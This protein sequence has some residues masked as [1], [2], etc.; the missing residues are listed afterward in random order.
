M[1]LFGYSNVCDVPAGQRLPMNM[2]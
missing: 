2:F 1:Q